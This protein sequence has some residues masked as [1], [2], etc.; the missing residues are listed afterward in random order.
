MDITIIHSKIATSISSSSKGEFLVLSL[1]G[2][3]YKSTDSG[4]TWSETSASGDSWVCVTSDGTGTNLAALNDTD[5][6]IYT[7][8]DSGSTWI[9]RTGGNTGS[10]KYF[11]WITSDSIG[12]NLAAVNGVDIY[13]SVNK[14]ITWT[15]QTVNT[16]QTS[17]NWYAITSNSTGQYL[18]AVVK[19]GGIYISSNTGA[20]WNQTSAPNANWV[21]IVSDSTGKYLVACI[22]NGGIYTCN[23][24]TLTN[25]NTGAW[26]LSSSPNT[27]WICLTIDSTGK[28]VAAVN[29]GNL[30]NNVYAL[31]GHIWTSQNFGS[32]W[33]FYPNSLTPITP[34]PQTPTLTPTQTPTPTL[35]PTIT[36]TLTPTLSPTP[37]IT[38]TS[39]LTPTRTPTNTPTITITRTITPTPT[40]TITPTVTPGLTP[41]PTP[42]PLISNNVNWTSIKSNGGGTLLIA[43]VENGKI[44]KS[45]DGGNTWYPLRSSPTA[46][47]RSVTLNSTSQPDNQIFTA[48]ENDI[49]RSIDNG[50]TWTNQ[51]YESIPNKPWY[52]VISSVD[53]LKLA[54]IPGESNCDIYTSTNSGVTWT[55]Q[56]DGTNG[57]PVLT[58]SWNSIT[59]DTSGTFLAATN[60]NAQ[61]YTST[62]SGVTWTNQTDGTNGNPILECQWESIIS[63]SY[64]D[65]LFVIGN[66][67]IYKS[68]NY[69]VTWTNQTNGLYPMTWIVIVSN[70]TCTRLAA[71]ANN[72]IWTST[73]GATWTNQTDGTNGKPIL[74]GPWKSITCSD[75][76]SLLAAAMYGGDIYISNDFGIT[77]YNKTPAPSPTPTTTPTPTPNTLQLNNLKS[78]VTGQYFISYQNNKVCY[79]SNGG[80]TWETY[81][82]PDGNILSA[83]VNSYGIFIISDATKTRIY[84][85]GNFT[86]TTNYM[87]VNLLLTDSPTPIIV[88]I[89]NGLIIS[90]DSGNKSN[91]ISINSTIITACFNIS[92]VNSTYFSNPD[93]LNVYICFISYDGYVVVKSL[94]ILNQTLSN[95]FAY[96]DNFGSNNLTISAASNSIFVSFQNGNSNGRILRYN[97]TSKVTNLLGDINTTPIIGNSISSNGELILLSPSVIYT[98]IPNGT[99]FVKYTYSNPFTFTSMAYSNNYF[100]ATNG[101]GDLYYAST[102]NNYSSTTLIN[103]IYMLVQLNGQSTLPIVYPPSMIVKSNKKVWKFQIKI[104]PSQLHVPPTYAISYVQKDRQNSVYFQ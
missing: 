63:N 100:Y 98:F 13:T 95:E 44:W 104:S 25:G 3:I 79:S 57:N 46:P 14:G 99:N 15:N 32:D 68:T 78:D 91:T 58:S 17:Q 43:S 22:D 88:G 33:S 92:L 28:Y 39:T 66:N 24:S 23:S 93:T 102:S 54:A 89:S 94:N 85:N 50:E 19:G 65:I 51:T 18:A 62:N 48:L 56:T 82:N 77:W 67:D 73:N 60:Y 29:S 96:K 97:R 20:S 103:F 59:C 75:N 81:N 26:I 1:Y 21:S 5:G 41:T 71:I 31:D 70:T 40:I 34:T 84:K 86:N 37:T 61:I 12:K 90:Y 76:F 69:G 74:T 47:W 83:S 11:Y 72:N 52:L 8:Q 35:T 38:K 4:L 87:G 45:E 55:N 2:G 30:I 27:S 101:N 53:G 10:G 80:N 7:S 6:N 16:S 9:N 42:T 49:W 36:P 64:G